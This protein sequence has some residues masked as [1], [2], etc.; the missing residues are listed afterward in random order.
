MV[1]F[2]RGLEQLKSL[3]GLGNGQASR[4]KI[5]NARGIFVVHFTVAFGFALK[6]APTSRSHSSA[7]SW[8]PR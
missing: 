3:A 7:M 2:F 6:N 4:E 5:D 8:C 1:H